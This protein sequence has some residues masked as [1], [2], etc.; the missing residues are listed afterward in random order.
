MGWVPRPT[1]LTAGEH[2]APAALGGPEAE[3]AGAALGVGSIEGEGPEAAL[4]TPRALHVLLGAGGQHGSVGRVPH[5]CPPW[6]TVSLRHG[7]TLPGASRKPWLRQR[8][9]GG[10]LS[11]VLPCSGTGL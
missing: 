10:W 4:V 7:L 5:P 2:G 9:V 6:R 8:G 1:H 3:A 11:P